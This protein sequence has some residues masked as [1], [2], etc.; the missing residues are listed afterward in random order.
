MEPLNKKKLGV[1]VA[2]DYWIHFNDIHNAL[3][4]K[5]KT[6]IFNERKWPFQLMSTRINQILLKHDL[7]RFMNQN[8]ILFFEWAEQNFVYATNLPKKTAIIVR[9]HLHE[10][11][12]FAP[13]ANWENVEMVILVSFAMQRKFLENFPRMEG[14][15][16]VIH[17]GVR[18]DR[19]RPNTCKFQGVIGTLSRIEPHKRI[20]D[21]I[22]VLNELR[23]LGYDLR[24]VIGGSCTESRYKRY[25]HEV[26]LLVKRLQLEPYVTFSGFV[27]DPPSWFEQLDIFVT[28]SCSEGLQVALLEAMATSC[29]CLSHAWDG[30]EEILPQSNVYYSE[31]QLIEKIITY[32]NEAEETKHQIKAAMRDIVVEKFNIEERKHDI[33]RCIEAINY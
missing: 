4:A 21:L 23:E 6:K 25:E 27:K 24:L 20:Y 2:Q 33:I 10:L 17:N 5:Y 22:I 18:L 30:V 3:Q 12:D 28:H 13:Q 19:F 15:T 31:N 1:I 29:Y 26:H 9:L 16:S 7:Y 14:R 8:D 11:W 32:V